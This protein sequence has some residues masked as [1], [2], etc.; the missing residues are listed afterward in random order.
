VNLGL[1]VVLKPTLFQHAEFWLL[2]LPKLALMIVVSVFAGSLCR[3]FCPA[4]DMGYIMTSK[5]S[6]FKVS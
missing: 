1:T 3:Y 5:N 6:W 4:D 2:Q